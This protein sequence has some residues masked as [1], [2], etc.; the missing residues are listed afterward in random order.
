M[1]PAS[2]G[3]SISLQERADLRV[4]FT[5]EDGRKPNSRTHGHP[6]MGAMSLDGTK[7]TYS[8]GAG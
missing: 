3:P 7:P 5:T 8:T 1:V 2:L 6:Q 4:G